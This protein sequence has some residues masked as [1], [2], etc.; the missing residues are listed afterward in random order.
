MTPKELVAWLEAQ[1]ADELLSK[2]EAALAKLSVSDAPL[3]AINITIEV[4]GDVTIDG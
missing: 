4:G 3:L 1:E 2:L